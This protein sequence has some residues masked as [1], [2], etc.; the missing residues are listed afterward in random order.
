MQEAGSP[1]KH[2]LGELGPG[3]LTL[4]MHKNC[5]LET[6]ISGASPSSQLR[7]DAE[8]GCRVL[9]GKLSSCMVSQFECV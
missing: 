5:N 3:M 9:R 7:W 1:P 6:N 4:Y 2:L 8:H